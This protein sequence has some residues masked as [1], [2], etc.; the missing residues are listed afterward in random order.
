MLTHF[1]LLMIRSL[2]FGFKWKNLND[3]KFAFAMLCKIQACFF[4]YLVDPWYKRY[5]VIFLW[6]T[7]NAYKLL[8]SSSL[9]NLFIASAFHISLTVLF[10]Y[11]F[12]YVFY[13]EGG[14]PILLQI[15]AFHIP[16]I[17]IL[18]KLQGFNLCYT[19]IIVSFINIKNKFTFAR[20][21]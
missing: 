15:K 9:F 4:I 6:K 2:G 12:S 17:I 16:P 18:T 8:I 19:S 10:H 11:R 3:L 7:S 13:V 5:F 21:Y 20:H 14:T 1:N